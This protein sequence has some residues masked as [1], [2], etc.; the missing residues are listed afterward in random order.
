[1][2]AYEHLI[3]HLKVDPKKVVALGDSTGAAMILEMLF[4]THDPSMFE[5]TTNYSEGQ[6]A[7]PVPELP[8]PAALVMSSP[9]V[10]ERTDSNSW[11][12]NTKYD[13]ITQYTAKLI[14]KDF[15]ESPGKNMLPD[16]TQHLGVARLQSGYRAFLP[17]TLMFVGNK[18]VLRD[19]ALEIAYKAEQDGVPVETVIED[20]V[21]DWFFVREIVKD[22]DIIKRADETFAEFCYRTAVAPRRLSND[23]VSYC[24]ISEGLAAVPEENDGEEESDDSYYEEFHDASNIDLEFADSSSM[25]AVTTDMESFS[26]QDK[27][28]SKRKT[29]S[30]P[31]SSSRRTMTIYV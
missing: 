4:I 3:T 6:T 11:M 2:R 16:A 22:K 8:R 17:Q 27:S 29:L 13:Y 21:H 24:P 10:T 14:I 7:D 25:S 20:C 1:M 18:E 9:L 15:F 28:S 23:N 26:T 30:D 19:D 12:E 5:I 31:K